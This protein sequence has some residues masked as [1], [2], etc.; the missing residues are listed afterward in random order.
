MGVGSVTMDTVQAW[1]QEHQHAAYRALVRV[2]KA[3]LA[4]MA[5]TS[6]TGRAL[7]LRPPK[8][9]LLTEVSPDGVHFPGRPEAF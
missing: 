7:R 5:M 4:G 8:F 2:E 1:W 3:K 9:R 6:Q